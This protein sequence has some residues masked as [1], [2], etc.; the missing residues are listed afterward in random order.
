MLMELAIFERMTFGDEV[1][2]LFNSE[3]NC[4]TELEL[5]FENQFALRM[6]MI[7]QLLYENSEVFKSTDDLGFWINKNLINGH[8][9]FDYRATFTMYELSMNTIIYF[10]KGGQDETMVDDPIAM[11]IKDSIN[12]EDDKH[13]LK[14]NFFLTI[15][16]FY[17]SDDNGK[18]VKIHEA[19]M[20]KDEDDLPA[21]VV[22]L[23]QYQIQVRYTNDNG[24]M[25]MLT[26]LE[27]ILLWA[28]TIQVR[29]EKML[30]DHY[31]KDENLSED[32][33]DFFEDMEEGVAKRE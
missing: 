8:N 21:L 27:R 20:I 22:Y 25:S 30:A 31:L 16:D 33:R 10:R 24:D 28:T 23:P 26:D 15:S 13:Y 32:D 9:M 4:P 29:A 3:P 14:N 12:Y 5:E 11:I 6:P 7:D 18:K 19:H 2:F 17:E 1:Q